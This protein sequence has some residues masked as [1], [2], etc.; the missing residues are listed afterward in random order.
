VSDLDSG[1]SYLLLANIAKNTTET[2]RRSSSAGI[3]STT[4]S[5]NSHVS[6]VF[7]ECLA[8]FSTLE[9]IFY[10]AEKGRK[11]ESIYS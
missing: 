7:F 9:K 2:Q 5:W 10:P 3:P 4:V 8:I 6:R 1:F 11:R